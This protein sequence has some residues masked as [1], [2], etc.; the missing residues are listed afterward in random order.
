[1]KNIFTILMAVLLLFTFSQVGQSVQ[2][3]QDYQLN[4]SHIECMGTYVEI[5]FV[6][7]NTNEGDIISDL[8]YT[9]G[10]IPPGARTGN[11]V[12]FTD[13]VAFGYYNIT[14][15]SV[16]VNGT[17]V[18]L[19]NPGAYSGYYGCQQ[20]PT[21]T[22][23]NPPTNTPTTVPTNTPTN[24]PTN[25]PTNTPTAVTVT[26]TD[27]PKLTPTTTETPTETPT[28][29]PTSAPTNTPTNTPTAVTVTPTDPPKLTPTTTETPT[30]TPTST[31][32]TP[33][34]PTE[35]PTITPDPSTTATPTDPTATV[36]PTTAIVTATFSVPN[37]GRDDNY[38]GPGFIIAGLI[39]LGVGFSIIKFL[40]KSY[41]T[42][43]K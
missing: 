28:N 7:L 17:E 13:N 42:R 21:N 26:P 41:T 19:H 2:A 15:A 3:K 38:S 18:T 32:T 36:S 43:G 22:P 12:H 24:V 33:Q 39:T 9:Y 27:P 8:T 23:T 1:M 31:P 30:E 37:T 25:T 34:T 35:T 5:H 14:S 20:Q 29:T 40:R 6:L 11:V 4:L 10:T 16:W